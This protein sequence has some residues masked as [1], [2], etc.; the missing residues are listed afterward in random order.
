MGISKFIVAN[1]TRNGYKTTILLPEKVIEHRDLMKNFCRKRIGLNPLF[2]FENS[3]GIRYQV[4]LEYNGKSTYAMFIRIKDNIVTNSIKLDE[5]TN[6]SY[7]KFLDSLIEIDRYVY[8]L[9]LGEPTNIYYP[10]YEF[11]SMHIKGIPLYECDEIVKDITILNSAILT[12]SDISDISNFRKLYIRITDEIEVRNGDVLEEYKEEEESHNEFEDINPV[13]CS[14][15]I[16]R[17]ELFTDKRHNNWISVC[18][19][20]SKGFCN[21]H[22]LLIN[23]SMKTKAKDIRETI[24]IARK[25]LFEIQEGIRYKTELEERISKITNNEL[26]FQKRYDDSM[27]QY[28]SK[29]SSFNK[30]FNDAK[31]QYNMLSKISNDLSYVNSDNGYAGLYNYFHN[32]EIYRQNANRIGNNNESDDDEFVI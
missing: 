11:N 27:I 8:L 9:E 16:I 28:L 13:N 22:S 2:E 32:N 17:I 7:S 15:Y 20:K 3:D 4:Y 25:M 26:D 18:A 30:I 10:L 6:G 5:M 1:N 21:L 23:K 19:N 29:Y 12:G 31:R 14:E 24:D